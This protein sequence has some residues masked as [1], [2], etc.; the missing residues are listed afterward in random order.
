LYRSFS[1]VAVSAEQLTGPPFRTV[2]LLGKFIG[3][4]IVTLPNIQ[5]EK[6]FHFAALALV[7]SALMQVEALRPS[8][9]AM[10]GADSMEM[11]SGQDSGRGE[12]APVNL[13]VFTAEEGLSHDGLVF[14]F[15]ELGEQLKRRGIVPDIFSTNSIMAVL[16]LCLI[17]VVALVFGCAYSPKCKAAMPETIQGVLIKLTE[18]T[19]AMPSLTFPFSWPAIF[20]G[21]SKKEE[22]VEKKVQETKAE[23]ST[24]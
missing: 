2:E 13:N 18:W 14:S 10:P 8:K 5:F 12:T 4:F 20:S 17:S 23:E 1:V 16:G 3:T 22:A 15:L 24:A 21:G 9:M 6:M 11:T 19:P 7:L